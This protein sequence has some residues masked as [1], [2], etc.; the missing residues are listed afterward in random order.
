FSLSELLHDQL[1]E[2]PAAELLKPVC[3]LM[4]KDENARLTSE[5]ALRTPEGVIARM[6]YFYACHA[7]E[8]KD[9]PKEKEEL[10]LAA[11]AYFKDADVLI[12]M[13]RL[14][15]A[16]DAWKAMTKEKI[17]IVTT[18]F[19]RLVD[20]GRMM[21]EA[22]EGDPSRANAL[23]V[24][25]VECNQY[26]WLVG[27]TFGD[28]QKAV[29]LSEESVKICRQLPERKTD[30]PGFLDTL[31]R[32]YYGAGDVAN[33]V[34]HQSM[35]VALNPVSGQIRRQLEFFQKEAQDRSIELPT[36]E[37]PELP[38]AKPPPSPAAPP[39]RPPAK[40]LAPRVVPTPSSPVEPRPK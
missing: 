31:G 25:A 22:A 28:Y 1:Q 12:A 10:K 24:Y 36:P 15:Q 32:A 6:H 23:W 4:Q 14:P 40:P 17:E 27:N 8:Q 13:Y 34:K 7:H 20:E 38:R 35:A 9:W 39:P 11:E 19:H 30:Y 2:L 21:V 18:E 37:S 3:D 5:Q 29:K 16:D 33:A 26:A